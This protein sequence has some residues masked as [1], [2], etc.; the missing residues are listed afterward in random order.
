MEK[1]FDNPLEWLEA[2]GRKLWSFKYVRFADGIVRFCDACNTVDN[3]I[4]IAR[5]R[6]DVP[7]V[8]AGKIKVRKGKW[9]IEEG[10]S[11]TL[12]L[13]RGKSDEKYIAKA[14]DGTGLEYDPDILTF[15]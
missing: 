15:F 4:D 7:P 2:N 9:C 12:N 5:T 10:G 3:H 1:V 14:L 11:F 6:P 13:N 8:F